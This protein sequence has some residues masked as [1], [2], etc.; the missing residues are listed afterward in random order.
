M[1]EIGLSRGINGTDLLERTINSVQNRD[2]GALMS[3]CGLSNIVLRTFDTLNSPSLGRL[4]P[5]CAPSTATDPKCSNRFTD[6][7]KDK[8]PSKATIVK[9]SLRALSN[10]AERQHIVLILPEFEHLKE[11]G[12]FY[13]DAAQVTGVAQRLR[14]R[15]ASVVVI[16]GRDDEWVGNLRAEDSYSNGEAYNPIA[17]AFYVADLLKKKS[18]ASAQGEKLKSPPTLQYAALEVSA[19]L[20]I[21][22][23][24]CVL[25]G[26]CDKAIWTLADAKGHA[27]APSPFSLSTLICS[28]FPTLPGSEES[29][30][31][32]C[33]RPETSRRP[34][35]SSVKNAYVQEGGGEEDVSVEV[36]DWGDDAVRERFEGNLTV[37]GLY[38]RN[39]VKRPSIVK[40]S[41]ILRDGAVNEWRAD[42]YAKLKE[43][44]GELE[45]EGSIDGVLVGNSPFYFWDVS[46]PM[47][48]LT[49]WTFGFENTSLPANL[50]VDNVF[51]GNL[52]QNSE[53]DKDYYY[54]GDLPSA[55]SSD[56]DT[57]SLFLSAKDRIQD[58]NQFLWIGSKGVVTHTHFDMDHNLFVQAYGNK[59]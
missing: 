54:L 15:G 14:A 26:R 9:A 6:P 18:E 51:R 57:F 17:T 50:L 39:G 42:G 2:F 24:D 20:R 30:E 36:F 27:A 55:L 21:L 49:N 44:L 13:A 56:L 47:H 5:H 37:L 29:E 1:P 23:R 34:L 16:A 31:E 25:Q 35:S 28:S 38:L 7:K 12:K 33:I 52:G 11:E 10:A 22:D 43:S 58:N 41:G 8:L 59:P 4:S 48:N 32:V 3:S 40:R 53:E 19:R 45:T 46:Q